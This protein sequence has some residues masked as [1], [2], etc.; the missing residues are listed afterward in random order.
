ML[1]ITSR[2]SFFFEQRYFWLKKRENKRFAQCV[3]NQRYSVN[4]VFD[5]CIPCCERAFFGMRNGPFRVVINALSAPEMGF[6][7]V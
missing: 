3:D 7:V 2:E 5:D 4:V 1:K 6:I